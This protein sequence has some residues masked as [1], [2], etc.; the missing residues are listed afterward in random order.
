[1]RL[2]LALVALLASSPSLAEPVFQREVVPHHIYGGG[3]EHFVGGGVAVFDC[4]DDR[5]PDLFVAGGENPAQLLVNTSEPRGSLTFQPQ[6]DEM[7][8]VTGAT[9]AYPMDVDNDGVLD[10]VVLRIGENVIL[11]G[12][13]S[14]SFA[15]MTLPNLTFGDRWTTAFTA[16]WEKGSTLP[17]LMFGN[18]V[19]RQNPEGPFEACDTN[20]LFRP[21]ADGYAETRLQ[22]GYCPLSALFSDWNRNGRADLRLSNDRH[23]Y[24]RGGA[25]Q[26]WVM[27]PEPRLLTEAEGWIDHELWGMGIASRDLDFD[28]L[29]E[30]FLTSMGDQR[31]QKLTQADLPTWKDV[32]YEMGTTAHRPH[33][34]GDGRPSTGW[35]VAFGDLQNDGLDDAF[36]AKGN[37]DQM[38]GSAMDDP[39]SLLMQRPDGTFFEAAEDAG[40][41][42]FDRSRGAALVDLN[43]DGLLDLVVVNRR[44]PLELY[45]NATEGTGN[46]VRF[47]LRQQTPNTQAVGAFLE[48]DL[49]T[50]K[51]LREV[52]VG[53][54]HA[55]GTAVPEHFGLGP[56]Q[57]VRV[58]VIWPG[59]VASDWV[60][61]KVNTSYVATRD[62]DQ[63]HLQSY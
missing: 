7:I 29:P 8:A 31:L 9:G 45:R 22:P 55:G 1:M 24:V 13:D 30:V 39:N 60:P 34:G 44:A 2:K 49:G 21:A 12:G 25:E 62:G 51:V 23:Y 4:N 27:E 32:P 10:L 50:H 20:D 54:G 58:R 59:G 14:C 56:S 18:Y 41:A 3:W 35:H 47:A 37:V 42:T 19:D 40:I 33:V 38:P 61:V 28:G 53:G 63:V 15:P 43:R 26:M 46:W 52:T 48:L 5:F 36:I 11:K 6:A 17:T 16:T 57:A